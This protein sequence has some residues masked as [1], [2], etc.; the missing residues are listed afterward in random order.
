MVEPIMA[1]IGYLVGLFRAAKAAECSP[2]WKTD[3]SKAIDDQG[4]RCEAVWAEVE[5]LS[6]CVNGVVA[7]P[8]TPRRIETRIRPS[9]EK[10]IRAEVARLLDEAFIESR[11]H[12]LREPPH[13]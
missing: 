7:N 8:E 5:R 11:K 10:A 2:L 13:D 1:D 9:V 12:A 6:G 3:I 4:E